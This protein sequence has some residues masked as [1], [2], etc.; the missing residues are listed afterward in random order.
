MANDRLTIEVEANTEGVDKL[1]KAL[2]K[3]NSQLTKAEKTSQTA[4]SSF[5]RISQAVNGFARAIERIDISPIERLG[6]ALEKVQKTNL[7]KL[8]SQLQQVSQSADAQVGGGKV[9]DAPLPDV[10]PKANKG[11]S[12]IQKLSKALAQLK[13]NAKGSNGALS[14]MLSSLSHM[15]L[16]SIAFSVITLVSDALT[17]GITNL[18]NYSKAVNNIDWTKAQQTMDSFATTAQQ[19]KNTLGVTVMSVLVAMKPMLDTI[20]NAFITAANAVN[21][22]MAALG[23]SATFTKATAQA[24]QWGETTS[25]AA[26]AAQNA[27]AGIDELNIISDSSGSGSSAST[28]DYS[29]MFEEVEIPSKIQEVLAWI[30]SHMELIKALAIGIGTALL[31][32]NILKFINQLMDGG[33]SLKQMLGIVALVAGAAIAV[34]EAFKMWNEGISQSNLIGYIA[35]VALACVGL[36]LLFGAVGVAIGL[37]VG[38]VALIVIAL[39][40]FITTGEMTTECFAAL[41][42]GILAVGVALAILFGWPAL[43]IAAIVALVVG[44]IY[45]WD[46][47][48]QKTSEIWN[49]IKDSLGE[50]WGNIKNKVSEVW[51]G[52]KDTISEKWTSIKTNTNN[53]W[54]NI[55]STISDKMTTI[56][57]NT[58]SALDNIKTKWSESWTNCKNT[59][60]QI[61]TSMW[62]TIKNVINSILG[63]VESMA[64]GV[65]NGI[66]TVIGAL[67]RL[68]FTVPDWVPGLGG[69]SWSMNISTLSTVSLPRLADGGMVEAGQLFIANEAG[70]ELVGSMNGNTTVAN[71]EQII[72]GIQNGVSMAVQSVLAP[73]LSE[74]ADNT[75]ETADKDFTVKIS[76][77]AIARANITGSRRLGTQLRT[78]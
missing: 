38:G 32:W 52:L 22:F 57:T 74:I 50:I 67:N 31:A 40:E 12:A 20:A 66:N 51:T 61:F 64:N 78:T 35:G 16:F 13:K 63:G 3:L 5:K 10:S 9:E 60:S 55:K 76:D 15:I 44:I 58:G 21:A 73:Y 39:H 7:A 28:P 68:K 24:K 34:Y 23:G 4:D 70:P 8:T 69:K 27:T 54:N 75:R 41:E 18:Y 11:S 48:K 26:K 43:L 53:T 62:N 17:T 45:Y 56:K 29:G 49:G 77:R 37:L 42:I 46:E 2:S 6:N 59:T 33:L 47:I 72:A 25:S 30:K 71:N 36:G 19:L 1:N 14:K 65:V